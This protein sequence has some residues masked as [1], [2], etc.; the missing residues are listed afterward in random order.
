M[1]GTEGGLLH[2]F[3]PGRD[4]AR[5]FRDALGTFGTGVTVVTA[6]GS[7]G[8]CGIT[9]NS[10]ASVSLD[11][12]LVLWSLDRGSDRFEVF[13]GA[14]HTAIHVLGQSQADLAMGFAR[15]GADFT[16]RDWHENPEGVPLLG[17]CLS[18][19]E[20]ET[21]ACHEGGDHVI[22]VSRVLRATVAAGPPLMFVGGRFG[23]FEASS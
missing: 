19:F 8:P 7:D 15:D 20:C 10:F 13:A 21:S 16:G 5:A 3:T 22:L 9:A 14:R 4:T 6:R 12:A 23:Q 17:G 1:D 18:R 2:S 11:P